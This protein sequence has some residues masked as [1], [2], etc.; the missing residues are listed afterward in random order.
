MPGQKRLIST[1]AILQ[2][3]SARTPAP[4]RRLVGRIPSHAP[5][6]SR[7]NGTHRSRGVPM[8]RAGLLQAC[9]SP[10]ME[11]NRQ[12]PHKTPAL[13]RKSPTASAREWRDGGALR[14][15]MRLGIHKLVLLLVLFHSA[16]L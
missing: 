6:T 12:P 16:D 4:Q 14:L 13:P 8:R 7:S 5:A 2:S 11:Q 3:T 9:T 1:A 10:H 15:E